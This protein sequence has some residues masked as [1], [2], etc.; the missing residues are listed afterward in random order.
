MFSRFLRA[1]LCIAASGALLPLGVHAEALAITGCVTRVDGSPVAAARISDASGAPSTT[2]DARGCFTFPTD[3]RS[4]TIRV[5]ASGLQSFVRPGVRAGSNLDIRLAS[6]TSSLVTI[7]HV[8][9]DRR[10]GVSTS[11]AP[12]ATLDMRAATRDGF[13]SVADVLANEISLTAI[14]PLGGG[15]NAPR[16]FALRG[17]DPT[18]TLI[19]IDGHAINNG[20]T[21]DFDLSLLDPEDLQSVELVYGI[22]PSSLV[23]PNT[24]GGAINVRTLE[25]TQT[26]HGLLRTSF[27]NNGLFDSSLRSTGTSGRIGYALSLHRRTTDNEPHARTI[28]FAGDDPGELHTASVGSGASTNSGLVKLR[29]A[30]G[31]S[32]SAGFIEASVRD[33]SS[34]RDQSAA[35][36]AL[37]ADGTYASAAGAF[38][39]AHNV[40]YDLDARIPIGSHDSFGIAAASLTLRHAMSTANQSVF[41]PVADS[42]SAYFFNDRNVT[43]DDTIEFD[44]AGATT[45][46]ALKAAVRKE[47]LIGPFDALSANGPTAQ[48][49]ARVL[50]STRGFT[51]G[52][53]PARSSLSQTQASFVARYIFD[54]LPR[55][56]A[57]LATYYS[58]FTSFGTSLDPR[59]GLVWTPSSRTAMRASFGTT[60]QSPS[61]SERFVPNPLPD[62][63]DGIVHVGNPKLQADH[64]TEYAFGI[65]HLFGGGAM[66][67]RLG[68]D[69]YHTNLRTPIQTFVPASGKGYSYPVNIGGAVYRGFELRAERDLVPGTHVRVG[70][71]IGNAYA[72]S[73]PPEI[74]DG[75][76]IAGKQFLGVPLQR[77]TFAIERDAATG[78][79]Y[80][81]GGAYE[82]R[83]NELNEPQFVT[84]NGAIGY[85]RA[86]YRIDL[87]VQ[88]LTNVYASGFT[89]AG[90]GTAYLGANGPIPLDAY[91]LPAR[92][93]TLSLSRKF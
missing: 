89:R 73:V 14:R 2:T 18:E 9:V 22:A 85:E 37:R 11:S 1:S 28:A 15:A 80:R 76:L 26:A 4:S 46:L 54:A 71:S 13:S 47:R 74:G 25:P 58:T 92:S 21:G 8:D 56:H 19:D 66:P 24:I 52:L 49:R 69:L 10:V 93:L 65:E 16:V 31:N 40:G 20:N 39:E 77:G 27:G 55:V 12:S 7:G 3:A 23:G 6:A 81:L 50:D 29:Y 61:L 33:Q 63:R 83:N 84:L 90:A 48:G 62:A 42:S 68:L 87:A 60:F 45:S 53:P 36:S 88:N 64:A 34:S 70:Y 59:V 67:T 35:L 51:S 44:R 78:L 17:P 91:V 79:S 41:G 43:T 82:G 30:L 5:D 38:V 57:T 32:P 86:A 72:T 75:S